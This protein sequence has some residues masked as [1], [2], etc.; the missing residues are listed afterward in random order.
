MKK[1]WQNFKNNVWLPFYK[2]YETEIIVSSIQG[3]GFG[4]AVCLG[5]NGAPLQFGLF[6]GLCIFVLVWITGYFFR[7]YNKDKKSS[8]IYYDE[9]YESPFE[10]DGA[11]IFAT[12]NNTRVK[13]LDTLDFSEASLQRM[14]ALAKILNGE[15]ADILFEPVKSE[16]D[17]ITLACGSKIRVR[18][19]GYMKGVYKLDQEAMR[20]LQDDFAAMVVRKM[21][22]NDFLMQL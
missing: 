5:P 4:F 16:N 2:K 22:T 18:G 8:I 6:L 21:K 15:K 1:Y 20:R 3:A 9:I 13:A 19:W 10:A 17:I 12:G 11:Y 14:Q 7:E